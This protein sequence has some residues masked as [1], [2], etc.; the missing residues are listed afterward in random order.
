MVPPATERW[1]WALIRILKGLVFD[2]AAQFFIADDSRL[3]QYVDGWLEKGLVREW[4]GVVGELE[5][6]GNFSQF[7]PS[8][9]PRYIAVHGMRSLADSL[10]LESIVIAHNGK[11]GT[12][13]GQF[14][15]IIIAHNGKCANRLLSASGLPLVAKQMKNFD[16]SSIWALLAAFDDPLPTVNFEGAFVKGVE[17]L[18]WMGNNSAKLA[19]L[20]QLRLVINLPSSTMI[21]FHLYTSH[22]V[23][24]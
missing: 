23:D 5:V 19:S 12:S 4:K 22:L 17:S 15:V 7:P 24:V 6:G 13:R 9:P 16:L 3:I 21:W 10:L 8:W 14:D 2:H 11:N 20:E 1:C 18:S